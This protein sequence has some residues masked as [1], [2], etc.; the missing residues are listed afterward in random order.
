MDD[1]CDPSS[2]YALVYERPPAPAPASKTGKSSKSKKQSVSFACPVA[3]AHFRFTVEGEVQ[4]TMTGLPVL[5]LSDLH[6]APS[7]QRR[8]VGKHVCQLMELAARKHA[9]QGFIV[10]V[11]AG[12][13]GVPARGFLSSKLRDFVDAR[14]APAG[15]NL[16]AFAKIFVKPKGA[17]TVAAISPVADAAPGMGD[18]TASGG[19]A[20]PAKGESPP[21]ASPASILCGPGCGGDDDHDVCATP[22]SEVAATLAASTGMNRIGDVDRYTDEDGEYLAAP[23]MTNELDA[24]G[25]SGVHA[26]ADAAGVASIEDEAHAPAVSPLD[27]DL[28]LDQIS[29]V[30]RLE[31][32]FESA[33]LSPTSAPALFHALFVPPAAAV[34]A[35]AT[36]VAGEAPRMSFTDFGTA[37]A[38]DVSDDADDEEAAGDD[39]EESEWEEVDSEGDEESSDEDEG[40]KAGGE[41]AVDGEADDILAQLVDLFKAENGRDPSEEEMAQWVQTLK[42]AAAEGGICL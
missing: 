22:S 3:F 10:L 42:E 40:D 7:H 38:E 12:A 24:A 33:A 35:A 11:P 6:V 29:P 31:T 36:P 20:R 19:S 21:W 4:E 1:L 15:T 30:A 32:A 41:T 37:A 8:G 16:D 5:L 34:A 28:N 9:M 14:Q 23:T 13:A 18:A 17:V 27:L 2:R 25:A 26:G 39:S